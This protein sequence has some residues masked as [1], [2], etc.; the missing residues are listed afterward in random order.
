MGINKN[1]HAHVQTW[2]WTRAGSSSMGTGL[3]ASCAIDTNMC[4]CHRDQDWVTMLPSI[5]VPRQ[6]SDDHIVVSGTRIACH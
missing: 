2:D 5:T 3:L 4:T 6:E 1:I